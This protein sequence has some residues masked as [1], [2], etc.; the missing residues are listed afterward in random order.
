MKERRKPLKPE[1]KGVFEQKANGDVGAA[2]PPSNPT[3]T[4]PPANATK[5][6]AAKATPKPPAKATPPPPVKSTPPPPAKSTPPP[7]VKVTPAPPAKATPA[8]PA[9]AT[10]A[11]KPPPAKAVKTQAPKVP[12]PQPQ[13]IETKVM[14]TPVVATKTIQFP[15][16][17]SDSDDDDDDGNFQIHFTKKV[18]HSFGDLSED[19]SSEDEEPDVRPM[20]FSSQATSI[21]FGED[22]EPKVMRPRHVAV[23]DDDDLSD[24][25]SASA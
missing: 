12:A 23:N 13:K 10:P 11:P 24:G 19:S 18:N 7:P 9:K 14:P 5:S 16:E 20:N 15:L 22:E 25:S 17:A 21:F 4:K 3:K 2:P 1:I 8:P 6:P